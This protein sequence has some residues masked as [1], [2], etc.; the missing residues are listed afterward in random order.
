MDNNKLKLLLDAAEEIN[1]ENLKTKSSNFAINMKNQSRY[2]YGYLK[3]D[4]LTNACV[5]VKEKI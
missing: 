5:L 3:I 2:S 4:T 1:R